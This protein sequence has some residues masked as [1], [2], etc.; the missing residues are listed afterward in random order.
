MMSLAERK[1]RKNM[2]TIICL[3]LI[4]CISILVPLIAIALM[5][6]KGITLLPVIIVFGFTL[7][8]D[9]AIASLFYWRINCI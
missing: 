8:I 1:H 6:E 7:L 2:L 4:A 5:Y 9:V 3:I